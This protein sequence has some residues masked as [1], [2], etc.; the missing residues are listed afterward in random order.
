MLGKVRGRGLTP[1]CAVVLGTLAC[2]GAAHPARAAV[3]GPACPWTLRLY[4]DVTNVAFPDQYANYFILRLPGEGPIPATPGSSLTITG[5]YPHARYISFTSYT[6]QTQALDGVN[7]LNIDPDPGSV[8]P[9]VPGAARYLPDTRRH[10]T[11]TALAG[12]RPDG[13]HNT[14]YTTSRDGSHTAP[15]FNIIFR[16]YRPDSG[17]SPGGGE[18]LPSVTWNV[19]GQHIPVGDSSQ[20]S[21]SNTLASDQFNQGVAETSLPTV[22]P[23][24]CYP[25]RN[26]PLWH[27]F[28]NLPSSYVQGTDS[29]CPT[30]QGASDTVYP[31]SSHLPT[32]GFLENLD[33]KYISALL[34]ADYFGPVI[35]IQ[36]RIPSTPDTF[37]HAAVMGSGQLR[38]WSMCTNDPISTRFFGCLMDDNTVRLDAA[39]D[40][41]L[42]ISSSANRPRNADVRHHVNWLPYGPLH[43]DVTIER[44]MLPSADFAQSIQR[45]G[46]GTEPHDLGV[47][48]PA[49]KYVKVADFERTGCAGVLGT[50]FGSQPGDLAGGNGLPGTAAGPGTLPALAVTGIIFVLAAALLAVATG[51]LRSRRG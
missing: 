43:T 30:G 12:Q 51:R 27:K 38:Y 36:S 31:V 1:L 3:S 18:P 34:N 10:Y 48:F 40:Y 5:L 35:V 49:A 8:N 41:C 6:P 23:G 28:L 44:N 22:L 37:N 21:D 26:P 45:A 25:G 15:D 20:C 4:A 19:N 46:Y 24:G 2:L 32:G 16:T 9:F 29:T 50:T 39:G 7:D 47:Y 14:V 13:R 33:N 17:F 11:V 42:V